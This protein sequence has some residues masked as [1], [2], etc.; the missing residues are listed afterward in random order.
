MTLDLPVTTD[1]IL[2]TDVH[3][4]Q[5]WADLNALKQNGARTA[6]VAAEGSYVTDSEGNK[7]I[8][9]IGGLWCV[10][11]GHKRAEIID[12]VTDQLNTLDFYSTFYSFTHP[13]A[14][15]LAEKLAQLAPGNLNKVHFGNSGS[16]ANETAVRVLHHYY[17]RLGRPKKRMVLSRHGAYHGSTHLA[18]AMTTPGYSEGWHKA[19]GVVHHLAK[20][21]FWREGD[22]MTEPEFLDSLMADMKASIESIGA[23]NIAC[24]IGEP[25][26]GAG[27]VI[28]P[29]AG[30]HRRAA[31][32]CARYDI[33]V[34][35]DEVVT[36]FGRLGHFFASRDLFDFQPDII[37]TAKGLTSGY[38][39]LSA[40]IFSDEVHEVI[41]APGA[42]FTH[43][44]TYSGHPAAAAA[45]LAN[46]ALM[47]RDDLPGQVQTT[48]KLF[49]NTLRGLADLDIVGEVRGSHFMMGIELVKD[50]ATKA[51]FDPDLNIG[52]R[53]AQAA[54]KRGL[55][56]RP[57]GNILILSPVLILT[58]A[59]IAEVGGILRDSIAE[60]MDDLAA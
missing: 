12:A 57:L 32:L 11:V 6:I 60:V 34:I 24:F 42:M 35:S 39:P 13:A 1:E 58:P 56:A 37:T 23:E 8:D 16:V 46:I 38:Q 28:V 17:K 44:M 41:S 15:A 49:E 3:L 21:H 52:M 31:E 19:E 22:G 10:N 7:L 26:M 5:S 18:I 25:I 59:Q 47:E 45:G 54:Q 53:V 9:G 29:P 51:M 48:G 20:P 30:Y 27:G 2:T 36:S 14:A 4:V 33:K 55:V 43:G 50:K 40:T